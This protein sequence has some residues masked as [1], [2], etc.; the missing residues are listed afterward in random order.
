ME[1]ISCNI[2]YWHP[3]VADSRRLTLA[4]VKFTTS[5]LILEG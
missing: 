1:D 3:A 5:E 4:G 2:V